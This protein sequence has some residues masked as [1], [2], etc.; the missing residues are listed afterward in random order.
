MSDPIA[1]RIRELEAM[2]VA[3]KA[4]IPRTD[5]PSHKTRY[6]DSSIYD[7]VCIYCGATDASGDYDL[8]FPCPKA[9]KDESND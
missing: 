3:E 1:K 6:S 2:I 9:P 7:E 8:K 5:H 4:K